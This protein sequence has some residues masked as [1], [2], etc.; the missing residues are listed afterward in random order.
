VISVA[1]RAQ[2]AT[3]RAR[4]EALVSRRPG[5]GLASPPTVVAAP[6]DQTDADVLLIDPGEQPPD[7]A[8]GA[9]RHVHRLPP[10]VLL[11]G[12]LAPAAAVRLLRA[13]VRAVLP[14]D[15][16]PSEVAAGI[17]AVAA[18]LVVLHPSAAP[19]SLAKPPRQERVAHEVGRDPLTPRELEILAMLAEGMG[20][21][22]IAQRLGISSHTV[23]FHVAA[24]LDK[25]S[26]RSRAEAVA[27]GLRRGLLMV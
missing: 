15:A 16:S 7:L 13:G 4:L 12:H 27:T 25:L 23:K 10:V 9:L 1:V 5:L 19:V 22:M 26:A 3:S 14:R 20:N 24:I 17:E 18:G 8:M 11:V 2:G 21:R 6:V